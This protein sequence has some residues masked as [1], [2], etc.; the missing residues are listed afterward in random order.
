MIMLIERTGSTYKLTFPT[1]TT[2][3]EVTR[4]RHHGRKKYA[5]ELVVRMDCKS[6]TVSEATAKQLFNELY[7]AGKIS[8]DSISHYGTADCPHWAAVVK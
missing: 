1:H 2:K 6:L 8:Q 7:K 4:M 5:S 3:I